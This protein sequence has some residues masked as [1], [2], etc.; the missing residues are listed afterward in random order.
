MIY[1]I[2]LNRNLTKKT[3]LIRQSFAC[4]ICFYG[5]GVPVGTVVLAVMYFAA[6]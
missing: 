5:T 4:N 3:A 1:S 6:A 2:C